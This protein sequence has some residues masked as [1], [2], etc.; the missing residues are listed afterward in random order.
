MISSNQNITSLPESLFTSQQVREGEKIVA[1][2]LGIDM[3]TLMQRKLAVN[4]LLQ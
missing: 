4:T 1:Q 3:Y 2:Q